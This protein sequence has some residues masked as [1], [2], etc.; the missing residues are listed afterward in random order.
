MRC[1][2]ARSLITHSVAD[3]A[4]S[5]SPLSQVTMNVRS[6]GAIG[7][8][9]MTIGLMQPLNAFIRPHKVTKYVSW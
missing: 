8:T 3:S 6:H 5:N 2:P 9:V 4:A 1:D 7:C